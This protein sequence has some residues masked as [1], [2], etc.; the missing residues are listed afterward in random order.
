MILLSRR[1]MLALAAVAD[2]AIHARPLPV[3]AKALSARLNLPP[4]HLETLL[5]ALVRTNI[6]KG[7]RGPRGGYELARERRRISAA[8]VIRAVM[9]DDSGEEGEVPSP[10]I[11]TVIGPIIEK[12][13]QT[14]LAELDNVSIDDIC[15]KAGEKKLF[16]DP[17]LKPDFTI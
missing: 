16:S 8:D 7:V 17:D 1:S 5:Q 6:L 10:F 12:A 15:Q 3:A 4:R 13:G 11:D 9:S 14:F 2:I